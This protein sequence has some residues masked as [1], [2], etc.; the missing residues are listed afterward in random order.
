M[1]EEPD[2]VAARALERA[3]AYAAQENARRDA[4]GR[5]YL[6]E[7]RAALGAA[8]TAR[9]GRLAGLAGVL[10]LLLWPFMHGRGKE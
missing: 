2:D 1:S 7:A 5:A 6:G 3:R 4:L 9:T 10:G 8:R